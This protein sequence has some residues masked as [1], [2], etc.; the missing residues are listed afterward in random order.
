MLTCPAV[1]THL[2]FDNLCA[3]VLRYNVALISGS[4]FMST[5][6]A[7]ACIVTAWLAQL[8]AYTRVVVLDQT[9]QSLGR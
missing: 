1:R 9:V 8:R 2:W 6:T 5:G 3:F 4:A 7:G